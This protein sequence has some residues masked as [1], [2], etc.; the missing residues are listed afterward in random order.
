MAVRR[1]QMWNNQV[2]HERRNVGWDYI[3][4]SSKISCFFVK[5]RIT[6]QGLIGLRQYLAIGGK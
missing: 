1:M 3:T 2:I 4:S 5:S 6:I